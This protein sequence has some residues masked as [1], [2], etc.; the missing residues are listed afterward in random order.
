MDA[1][2]KYSLNEV[3]GSAWVQT[4]EKLLRAS[5]MFSDQVSVT[6]PGS[7]IRISA[8]K[9]SIGFTIG[10]HYHREGPY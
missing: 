7:G 4:S 6:T 3:V 9:R 10:F 5:L 2:C 8:V 1:S